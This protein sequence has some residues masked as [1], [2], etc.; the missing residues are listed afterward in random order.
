MWQY[1]QM[2]PASLNLNNNTNSHQKPSLKYVNASTNV[3]KFASNKTVQT[4]ELYL[5]TER[6]LQK[7]SFLV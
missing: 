5:N 7:S 6:D 4:V 1:D 2:L 3:V